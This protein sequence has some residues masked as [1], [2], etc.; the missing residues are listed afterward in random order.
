MEKQIKEKSKGLLL[1]LAVV[2]G[3]YFAL[4]TL[5]FVILPLALG[6][7]LGCYL[8]KPVAFLKDRLRFPAGLA[9]AV[10]VVL[11]VG[12]VVLCLGW[13]A[14]KLWQEAEGL[15]NALSRMMKEGAALLEGMLGRL[16]GMFN[17]GRGTLR[18]KL[19]ELAMSV[20]EQA[21]AQIPAM[22]A[23]FVG[24][25]PQIAVGAVVFLLSAFYFCRDFY[26]VNRSVLAFFG[27]RAGSFISEFKNQFLLTAANYVKAYLFLM[28]FSFT[29][30]YFG[31]TVLRVPYAFSVALIIAVVDILPVLGM[32][33]VVIPWALWCAVTGNYSLAVG[34]LV[35]FGIMSVIR[36]LAEPKIVGG[37]I[38]LHPLVSLLCVCIGLRFLGVGGML[39]FPMLV[40]VLKKM[41]QSGHLGSLSEN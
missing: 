21:A 16:D 8:Q 9:A 31:L 34:L 27:K 26:R 7:I 6:W 15:G 2:L 14:V 10:P 37:F 20:A 36:Q 1:A 28:L 4:Q 40:I 32:G 13:S 12:A 11:T 30:L 19:P 41:R 18:E 33:I 25:V 5:S 24:A 23:G 29:Q 38:G 39:L 22:V 3:A 17:G 35:L